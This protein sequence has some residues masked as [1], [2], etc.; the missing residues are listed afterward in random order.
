MADNINNPAHYTAGGIEC[1]DA[2]QA[3]LNAEEFRGFCK[4]NV[5]KYVWRE[6]QKGGN[7]SVGKADWYMK[8]LLDAKAEPVKP[9]D[10]DIRVAEHV[11]DVLSME[12]RAM[13]YAGAIVD[14]LRAFDIAAIVADLEA[15]K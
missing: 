6:R 8:R 12:L 7:E 11:R 4:G 14:E 5:L 15:A 1:I 2:I 9:N 10:R 3:A 13:G